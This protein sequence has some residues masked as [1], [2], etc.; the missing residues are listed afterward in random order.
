[1]QLLCVQLQLLLPADVAAALGGPHQHGNRGEVLLCVG[2]LL[3]EHINFLL[4]RMHRRSATA[5]ATTAL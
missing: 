4:L 5:S 1:M 2:D 3:Q